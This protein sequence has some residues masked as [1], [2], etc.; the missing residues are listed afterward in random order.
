MSPR[1]RHQIL[2]NLDTVYREA[3]GRAKKIGDDAR[4]LDLDASY[5]REQLILEVLLDVRDAL[6]NMGEESTSKTSLEK[7]AALRRLTRFK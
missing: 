3:Y 7:L 4:M 6:I 5:Q 2:D 1:S